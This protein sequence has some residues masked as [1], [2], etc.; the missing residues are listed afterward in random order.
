MLQAIE[1]YTEFKEKITA[2]VQN[3][4]NINRE[5][6]DFFDKLINC[7]AVYIVCGYIRDIV[8]NKRS[9]DLDVI[10]N[11][12]YKEME[13]IM[14]S[15]NVNYITNRLNGIKIALNDMDIDLWSIENNWAFETNTV[16]KNEDYVLD[17]L[18]NGCFYNYDTL[19]LNML[20]KKLNVR[21]FNKFIITNKLDII[22]KNNR[23][24]VLSP[25]IE[26]NIL[27]AFYIKRLLK[28]DYTTNCNNYLLARIGYLNDKYKSAINRL[29]EC[30]EKYQKY[31]EVLNKESI[32]ECID[33]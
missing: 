27:R 13:D 8:F 16:V 26:G 12:S 9:R 4:L 1:N 10:I 19:V 29:L 7:G 21:H 2:K 3:T 17:S 32:L 22:Q 5:F 15:S 14:K 6:S 31:D 30:K 23:Y 24:K 25:R 11:I 33:Y 18:A 20:T 28:S